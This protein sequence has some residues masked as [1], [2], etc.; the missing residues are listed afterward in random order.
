MSETFLSSDRLILREFSMDDWQAVHKYATDP[1]VTR[2]MEWGPNTEQNTRDFIRRAIDNRESQPRMHYELAIS[3][4]DTDR[5]IGGCAIAVSDPESRRGWIG[6]CLNRSCWK[7]GFAT[8]AAKTLVEFGFDD[9]NLHRI[10]ATCD[11][12]NTAS[13]RVLEKIG[14]KREGLLREEKWL[15]GRWRDSLVY[16]VLEDEA[17]ERDSAKTRVMRRLSDSVERFYDDLAADYHHIYADWNAAIERQSSALDRLIR[18]QLKTDG[19]QLLDC[20]C[21]IGTQAIGLAQQGYNVAAL[22]Y[23]SCGGVQGKVGSGT[24][25]TRHTIRSC[26]FKV[27]PIR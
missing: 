23:Q 24:Q 15:K 16:A 26:R 5:L 17:R 19:R 2:F 3:L 20:S 22:R 21:G 11:A 14:M 18:D 27:A 8:E 7:Q 10:V 25:G 4:R 6:Y 13:S 9:L 12:E 1:E